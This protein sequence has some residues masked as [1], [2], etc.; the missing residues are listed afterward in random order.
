[1]AFESE[2]REAARLLAALEDARLSTADT[3][4]L[5]EAADPALVYLIFGWLRAWYPSHHS[6][7]EGVMARILALCQAS[8]RTAKVARSGGD[9]AIVAWFEE[10]YAYRELDRET[11]ISTVVDKLEG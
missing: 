7:H 11:F 6:A 9:D 4:H 1:M 5:A 10:T 3:R 8:S 2:K